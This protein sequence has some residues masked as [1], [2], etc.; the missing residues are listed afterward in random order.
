MENFE[1]LISSYSL[2]ETENIDTDQIIPAVHLKSIERAN[3]GQFLFSNW[4]KEDKLDLEK[5]PLEGSLNQILVAGT[6]FGCGSSREHAVWALS[7]Y[8]F[9]V[10]LSTQIA[11]IFSL[12]AL[13]N[14]L[15]PIKIS[16]ALY[17][18]LVARKNENL[19]IEINLEK[20]EVIVPAINQSVSFQI[21]EFKRQCLLNGF[22]TVD[23]L[24]SIHNEIEAYEQAK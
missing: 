3:F 15:L 5:W 23:Y 19:E 24:C 13:N 7:D 22:D 1:R 16:E 14:G 12:N 21:S 10:V 8:G 18:E 9:K 20:Q 17:H 2:L 11:D 6:N 4:R